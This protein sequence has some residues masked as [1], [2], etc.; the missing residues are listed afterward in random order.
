[1]V[2]VFSRNEFKME[3]TLALPI[4]LVGMSKVERKLEAS[5]WLS[6]W[7]NHKEPQGCI[8]LHLPLW[9]LFRGQ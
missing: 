4:L 8:G 7:W 9:T 6:Q 3:K 5:F 1:M 2:Y